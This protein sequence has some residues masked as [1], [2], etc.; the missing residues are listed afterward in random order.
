MPNTREKLI[1]LQYE[2]DEKCEHRNCWECSYMGIESCLKRMVADNLISN[3]VTIPVHCKDCKH[4][5]DV[6][7]KTTEHEKFC[8]IGF[9]KT[10]ENG[11]CSFGER[12]ENERKAD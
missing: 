6:E 10:K 9:Y 12:K 3:G 8:D 2:C 4:W 5:K 11:F 1:E 7:L